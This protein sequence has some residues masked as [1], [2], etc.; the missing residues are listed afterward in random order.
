MFENCATA[1]T[2]GN[3]EEVGFSELKKVENSSR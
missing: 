1:G 3:P 2:E